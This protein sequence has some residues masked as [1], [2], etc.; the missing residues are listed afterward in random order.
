MDATHIDESI[1]ASSI[2]AI[3]TEPFLGSPKIGEGKIHD[4][5]DIQ[6]IVK[7]LDKLYIGSLRAW[8][9]ILK[10]GGL[11]MIALPSFLIDG[12]VYSVK[13]VVDTCENLGYT[14]LLGPA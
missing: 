9:N 3:V 4:V 14:K 2:D 10:P 11:V 12:K 7:G 1:D 5:K 8:T 13:K 6:D